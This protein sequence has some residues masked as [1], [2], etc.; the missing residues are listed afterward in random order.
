MSVVFGWALIII[1]SIMGAILIL[2]TF[3]FGLGCQNLAHF[4][5]NTGALSFSQD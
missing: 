2:Q 1:S 3:N 4:P 5:C